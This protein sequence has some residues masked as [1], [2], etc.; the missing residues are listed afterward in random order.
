MLLD[1]PVPQSAR[2]PWGLLTCNIY[3]F[4]TAAA[5]VVL[6]AVGLLILGSPASLAIAD[7]IEAATNHKIVRY[8]V[9]TTAD[10]R[11]NVAANRDEEFVP[12]TNHEVVYFDLTSPRFRIERHEQT[13]ND[14]VQS[15]WV[16]VQN[17]Q[18]DRTLVTSSLALIVGEEQ[19]KDD[20]QI[21][22][23]RLFQNSGHAG[24]KA[25]LFRISDEGVIPFTNMKSDKTFLEVLRSFQHQ[26]DIVSASETIEGQDTIKYQLDS[27]EGTSILWVNVKSKLP[28]RLEVELLNPRPNVR[29]WKWIYTDFEWDVGVGNINEFFSTTPPADYTLEDHTI[30]K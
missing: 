14:T 11:M 21:K 7:I 10:I 5:A 17:N 25:R 18:L 20:D 8:Q 24:K 26:E 6:L 12:A 19:A 4:T 2:G 28:V 15:D 9:Q 3:R 16:I 29:R 1:Q 23:I 30:D 22:M 13:L 27:K